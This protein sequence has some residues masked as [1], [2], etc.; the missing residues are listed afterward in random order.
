MVAQGDPSPSMEDAS[1]S[2]ISA[3]ALDAYL[4]WRGFT[5]TAVPGLSVKHYRSRFELPVFATTGAGRAGEPSTTALYVGS[6]L[7]ASPRQPSQ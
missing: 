5:S 4:P 3:W 1:A 2:L 7:L 6:T